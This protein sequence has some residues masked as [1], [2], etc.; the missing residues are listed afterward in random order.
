MKIGRKL[1]ELR[2]AKNFSQG[3]IEQRTGLLR[4]YT[5][6]V[7]NGHI[8]PSIATLEKYAGALGVPLYALFYDGPRST[9]LDVKLENRKTRRDAANNQ[10]PQYELFVETVTGLNDSSGHCSCMWRISWHAAAR[11]YRGKRSAERIARRRV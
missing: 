11:V 9:E 7:E 8:S 5:A 4:A 6:R 10:P 1:C 3:D 2:L